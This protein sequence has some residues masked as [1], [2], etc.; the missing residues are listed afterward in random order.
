MVTRRVAWVMDGGGAPF[1]GGTGIGR[2]WRGRGAADLRR[3]R[4]A[5][6]PPMSGLHVYEKRGGWPEGAKILLGPLIASPI[7]N[8]RVIK[9][10]KITNP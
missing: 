6:L 5:W 10:K 9:F 2:L 7:T 4:M 1:C 8:P 3:P